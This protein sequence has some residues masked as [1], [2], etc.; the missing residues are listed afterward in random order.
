MT[1]YTTYAMR[2]ALFGLA[3]AIAVAI[4]TGIAALLLVALAALFGSS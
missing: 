4:G 3:V 1:P 2:D